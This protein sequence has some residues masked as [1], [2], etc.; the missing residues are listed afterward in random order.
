MRAVWDTVRG[1]NQKITYGQAVNGD[2][3][4]DRS[5]IP[6]ADVTTI[7]CLPDRE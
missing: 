3:R 1:T 7:A 5:G 4:A 2:V 6:R